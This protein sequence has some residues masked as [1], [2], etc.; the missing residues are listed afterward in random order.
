MLFFSNTHEEAHPVT[1]RFTFDTESPFKPNVKEKRLVTTAKKED[2]DYTADF[3]RQ[4]LQAMQRENEKLREE[5]KELEDDK[6]I[7]VDYGQLLEAKEN[8]LNTRLREL[9]KSNQVMMT[10]IAE[11]KKE[12]T[13]IRR[14]LL[15]VEQERDGN[16]APVKRQFQRM[17]SERD[18]EIRA[19]KVAASNNT[20]WRTQEV[21]QIEEKFQKE[22]ESYLSEIQK[23]KGML[24]DGSGK[25]GDYND[26]LINVLEASQSSRNEETRRLRK[27]VK[28]LKNELNNKQTTQPHQANTTHPKDMM[29]TENFS[30]LKNVLISRQRQRNQLIMNIVASAKKL[31]ARVNPLNE[32]NRLSTYQNL[33]TQD[34]HNNAKVAQLIKSIEQLYTSES[35]WISDCAKLLDNIEDKVTPTR[36]N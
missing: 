13:K 21:S 14:K 7:L 22:R 30:I 25:T 12:N 23:L 16:L 31:E 1:A 29:K 18:A 9:H 15:T 19:L 26:K 2:F 32:Q 3:L 6:N 35:E 28:R 33:A 27:E 11:L 24:K 36:A 17:L 8:T 34:S 4:Q 20:D 5:K 10:G